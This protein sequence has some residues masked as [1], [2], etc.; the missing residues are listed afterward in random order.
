MEKQTFYKL[1]FKQY[2][3]TKYFIGENTCFYF[4]TMC[5]HFVKLENALYYLQIKTS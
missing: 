3:N 5:T 4:S 2:Y 1:T